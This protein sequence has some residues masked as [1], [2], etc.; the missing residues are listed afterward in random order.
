MSDQ[1][2]LLLEPSDAAR[3]LGIT[4]QSVNQLAK[5]GKLRVVAMT[6]R[7]ISLY[8][9]EDVE[10]ERQRREALRAS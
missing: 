10:R 3:I 4:A 8:D 9:P 6:P 1:P 2:M 7:R 5:R